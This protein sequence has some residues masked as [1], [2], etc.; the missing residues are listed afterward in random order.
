MTRRL[1]LHIGIHKTAS[2]YLQQHLLS[3]RQLLATAGILVPV[4]GS[5]GGAMGHHNLSYAMV[6]DLRHRHFLG[7]YQE[8][9][10]EI[11]ASDAHTILISS[12]AFED[13]A[14]STR[15][16][17]YLV[18]VA[19]LVDAK[20]EIVA[21]VRE[22]VSL[23]N[24]VYTQQ[25]KQLMRAC[26][27]ETFLDAVITTRRFWYDRHF[28]EIL[29]CPEVEF[30]AIP[31]SR[32]RRDGPLPALFEPL[33]LDLTLLDRMVVVDGTT[34]PSLGPLAV[35]AM[36]VVGLLL[37]GAHRDLAN[38]EMFQ[39]L[40]FARTARAARNYCLRN[41]WLENAYWGWSPEHAARVAARFADSNAAF[42]ARVWGSPWPD[43]PTLDRDRNVVEP[44]DFLRDRS[45][46]EIAEL[47]ALVAQERWAPAAPGMVLAA[48]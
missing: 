9:V 5:S 3:N 1:I 25:V 39:A 43:D 26:T 18:G 44:I 38:S 16:L 11:R 23:L 24:S 19:G 28:R 6:D 30:V 32:V 12:E 4:T 45:D 41:G 27:F 40:R 36:Q 14:T 7:T 47:L 17:E 22:Q 15:A 20:L 37:R 8:L 31:F 35:A 33:G 2:T 13:T 46:E 34:N 48:P 42:A 29:A 21:V 10:A